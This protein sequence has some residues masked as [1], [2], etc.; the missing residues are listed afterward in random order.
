MMKRFIALMLC[1]LLLIGQLAACKPSDSSILGVFDDWLEGGGYD[2]STTTNPD[3]SLTTT[4]TPPSSTTG[5]TSASTTLPTTVPTTV[6]T[7]TATT[8][9]SVQP[10]TVP[11][12]TVTVAPT[13]T[14]PTAPTTNAPTSTVTVPQ[15]TTEPEVLKLKRTSLLL[16]SIGATFDLSDGNIA[17]NKI[18][19]VSQNENV[20]TVKNGVVTAKAMG[21]TKV[22]ASYKGQTLSCTVTVQIPTT[23]PPPVLKLRY[24]SITLLQGSTQSIYNGSINASEITW[25]SANTRIATV[26]GGVVKAIAPGS[27]TVTAYY[28]DQIATCAVTVQQ[29]TT[30][31]TT[32]PTTNPTTAP[33][34]AP[35]TKPT[36]APTTAPTTKPTTTAT[37]TGAPATHSKLPYTGRY[38]Y[39]LLTE[40]EKGWY[41]KIDTA[42]NNLEDKVSLGVDLSENDRYTIYFIYMFDNPEHFYLGAKVAYS[43]LGTLLFSYSDGTTNSFNGTAVPSITAAMKTNIRARKAAFDAEVARIISAIPTDIADVEKQLMIYDRL[44]IDMSYNKTAVNND[45]WDSFA[46]P[47][48]TAYGGIINKTGVCEA[49]AEAFQTLCYAVGINCTGVVGTANGGGHKWNAVELDGQWYQCDVTFDDPTNGRPGVAQYHAYFNLTSAQIKAKGHSTSG[50]TYPGPDCTATKYSYKNYFG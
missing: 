7:T 45:L 3:G 33:T 19:W 9:P 48:W 41:R 5:T 21:S 28:Q 25:Q 8:V 15:V 2:V 49:Y 42:V 23:D 40:Q 39:N 30:D 31:P 13:T 29:P 50:S 11:S 44:L 20:V 38:L 12:T 37:T 17:P 14:V 32:A 24:A 16:E 27:T 43:S 18:L 10:T 22:Y 36:T 6:P 1:F 46:E 35:T 4:L 47:N 34:T 26:T